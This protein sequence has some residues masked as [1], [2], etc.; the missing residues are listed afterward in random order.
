MATKST[1]TIGKEITGS[2][3]VLPSSSSIAASTS[4]ELSS[5]KTLRF[6]AGAI[7]HLVRHFQ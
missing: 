1:Y 2:R 7:A 5:E 4:A 3:E 6:V